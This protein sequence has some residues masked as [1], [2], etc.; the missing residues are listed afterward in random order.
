MHLHCLLPI[1]CFTV[2]AA[3]EFTCPYLVK[4]PVIDADLADW[5]DVA[6][7]VMSEVTNV[8]DL[9]VERAV[10]GWDDTNLYFG[11]RMRDSFLRNE[12]R[13]ERITIGDCAE[14]RLLLPG[15]DTIHLCIA[16]ISADGTPAVH[17]SRRVPHKG[18]I[19]ELAAGTDPAITVQGV[20][21][22]VRSDGQHWTVECA[23]PLALIS[24]TPAH[25]AGYPFVV[26]AWDQDAPGDWNPWHRRSESADQKKSGTWPRLMLTK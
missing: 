3:A 2:A 19:T 13:G 23:V 11:L 24:V 20:T 16:P 22:A 10:I 12:S 18:P 21:W 26:V 7:V 4:P 25:A 17:L 1:L 15:G 6:P 8:R 14:L 5:A 9:R